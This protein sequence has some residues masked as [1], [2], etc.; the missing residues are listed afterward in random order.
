[1][2]IKA[3]PYPVMYNTNPSIKNGMERMKFIPHPTKNN[4]TNPIKMLI[5]GKIKELHELIT[6]PKLNLF[7]FTSSTLKNMY[8][9]TSLNIAP[10]IVEMSNIRINKAKERNK[11]FE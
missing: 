1:M 11:F 10:K 3:L 7:S 2:P 5:Q 6:H 4:R 9:K 8:V